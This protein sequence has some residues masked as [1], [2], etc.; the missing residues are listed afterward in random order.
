MFLP[1]PRGKRFGDG[2][3][4]YFVRRGSAYFLNCSVENSHNIT[5]VDGERLA[6]LIPVVLVGRGVGVA[7]FGVVH[8]HRVVV[9]LVVVVNAVSPVVRAAKE[10]HKGLTTCFYD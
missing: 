5:K 6:V 1:D 10:R 8:L 3:F 7:I 9:H 4:Q 2:T